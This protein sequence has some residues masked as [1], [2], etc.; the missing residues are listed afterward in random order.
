[1]SVVWV[2]KKSKISDMEISDE[3]FIVDVDAMGDLVAKKL[4]ELGEGGVV[5]VAENEDEVIGYITTTDMIEVL[6][7]G[8]NPLE[9]YA[10]EL[11][12]EDFMEVVEDEMLGNVLPLLSERYPNAVVVIDYGGKCKGFFSV[13]DYKDALALLG[14]YDKSQDPETPD[15]WKRRGIAMSSMGRPEKAL[16]CYENSLAL[17][18]DKE[19]GWFRMARAFASMGRLKDA[20]MCY[21]RVCAINPNNEDAWLNRGNVSFQLRKNK[22]AAK[23]FLR[24]LQITPD[25]VKPLLN[26]GLVY[27]DMGLADKAIAAFDKVVSI[28]GESGDIWYRKGNIYDK[29]GDTKKA[30][31]CYEKA[32]RTDPGHE[33]AW[34]NLGATLHSMNKTKKAI[35]CFEMVLQINPANA[36]ARE[37]LAICKEGKGIGLF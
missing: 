30:V 25:G 9:L 34:F 15:E 6:A 37:A 4:C 29:A 32:T 33:E 19:G 20:S 31:K 16:E 3:F 12:V 13:N 21:G 7:D 18:G 26:L 23:A 36:D 22:Q 1:M 2:D 17:V 27:T 28:A 11:M 14:Y 10:D 35:R 5:L 8:E 24:A